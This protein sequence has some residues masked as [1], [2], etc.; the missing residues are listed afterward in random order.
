MEAFSFPLANLV[1]YLLALNTATVTLMRVQERIFKTAL[2]ACRAYGPMA[3]IHQ[4]RL[5]CYSQLCCKVIDHGGGKSI[6]PP[7]ASFKQYLFLYVNI[8]ASIPI[9]VMENLVLLRILQDVAISRL[10]ANLVKTSKSFI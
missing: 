2:P 7:S 10:S 1:S 9:F 5:C 4:L 8:M 3:M 6:P